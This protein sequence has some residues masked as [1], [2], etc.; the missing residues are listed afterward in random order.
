MRQPLLRS[1]LY[2]T[3][4]K[5][6]LF[7]KALE[8]EADAVIV[9]LEDGVAF[10]RKD[11][12]RQNL[13]EYLSNG[14]SKPVFVRMNPL[15]SR[16]AQ[17]DIE[18]LARLPLTGI[19][20]PKVHSAKDL[21]L[22]CSKLRQLEYQGSLQLQIE[23]AMGVMN[24]DEIART[25]PMIGVMG[26][27]EEDLRADLRCER[28]ILKPL[29]LKLVVISRAAELLPPL[30]SV[31]PYL[32]DEEG[33]K[34]STRW[35]KSAGFFGR[36]TVHPSQVPFINEILTPTP[37]E[38]DYAH[39]VITKLDEAL[40]NGQVTTRDRSDNYISIWTKRHAENLLRL[41]GQVN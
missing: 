12:A 26:I 4:T 9:D 1:Y 29:L 7:E 41:E 31:Y 30:M 38:I 34:E 5:L 6:N 8:S 2:V 35:G 11:E 3:A 32:S 10:N 40:A 33:F 16:F 13:A 15:H 37:K 20:I 39:H 21:S 28:F 14:Y 19:R 22:A 23:A 25:D 18:V 27:G 24:M 17:A 36:I